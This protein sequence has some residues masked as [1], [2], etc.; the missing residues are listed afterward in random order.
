MYEIKE[1][2]GS[3]FKNEHKTEDKH[4]N[5][6]GKINVDG[7]IKEIALWLTESKDGTKKYFSVKIQDEYIKPES[8]EKHNSETGSDEKELPDDDLPF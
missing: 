4:P 6:K 3:I 1:N 8:T 2:S 5:Y 7:T